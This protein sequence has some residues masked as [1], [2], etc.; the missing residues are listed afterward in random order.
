MSVTVR[1]RSSVLVAPVSVLR[2]RPLPVA[3]KRVQA[4]AGVGTIRASA[5]QAAPNPLRAGPGTE[6]RTPPLTSTPA[7]VSTSL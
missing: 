6:S 2:M 1:S 3:A 7:P 4:G 5:G